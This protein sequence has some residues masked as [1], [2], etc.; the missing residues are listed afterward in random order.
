MTDKGL[1]FIAK[2]ECLTH[3]RLS[4][5]KLDITAKG[6]K[7]LINSCERLKYVNIFH[8]YF[9]VSCFGYFGYKKRKLLKIMKHYEKYRKRVETRD[10]VNTKP[11]KCFWICGTE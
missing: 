1:N 6:L 11:L 8:C 5:F 4:S 2:L 7:N 10:E 3:L 9:P